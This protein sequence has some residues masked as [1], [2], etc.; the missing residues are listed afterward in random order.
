MIRK[1]SKIMMFNLSMTI[2]QQ[3][4]SMGI[5]VNLDIFPER[6]DPEAWHAVYLE[7]LQLLQGWPGGIL[8]LREETVGGHK[9]L[10]YSSHIE[11][12]VDNPKKRRWKVEGDQE[13]GETGETFEL[14]AHLDRYYRSEEI[15]KRDSSSL[16]ANLTSRSEAGR[17]VFDS[18][19]QGFPYHYAM[20]AVAMLV[21]DAF[22]EA[23][24]ACG[25]I[26]LDQARKA[27]QTIREVLGKEVALPL[28]VDGERLLQAL[29]RHEGEEKGVRQFFFAYH[30]DDDEAIRIAARNVE[31]SMLHRCYAHLLTNYPAP[32]TVGFNGAC[33]DWIN[34]D[35]DLAALIDM[36]CLNEAGP[37]VDPVPMAESLVGTWLTAPAEVIASLPRPEEHKVESPGI[38]DLL[39][40]SMMRMSGLQGLHTRVHVDLAT[41]L[42]PFQKRFPDRYEEIRQAATLSHD[43]LQEQLKGLD[44]EYAQLMEQMTGDQSTGQPLSSF[45]MSDLRHLDA[46]D[47]LPDEFEEV[48]DSLANTMRT[49][50]Q[51][52]LKSNPELTEQ[53]PDQI[54]MFIYKLSHKWRMALTETGWRWIDQESDVTTLLLI[55]FLISVREDSKRF[56]D[57]RDILLESPVALAE[58]R[59]RMK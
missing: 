58:L 52:M 20:L 59:D 10:T 32:K 31:P 51:Q 7:T 46:G 35:G 3:E 56:V 37:R 9:R 39:T 27:Q 47:P 12:D 33:Q 14:H 11:H 44:Q 21:E 55:L 38:D 19:T 25:N 30:G 8:G 36:A 26:T 22:P 1:T 40:D 41:L 48:L 57:F 34:A 6:I 24:L 15:I 17:I 53:G 49:G 16:L 18:K 42:A 2:C 23:A 54:R 28:A 4:V 29:I 50:L 45:K 43:K 13:S 5:H